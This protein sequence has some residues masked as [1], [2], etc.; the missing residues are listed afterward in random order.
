M[1]SQFYTV[2][3]NM[4]SWSSV[5]VSQSPLLLIV[6]LT[7]PSTRL[8]AAGWSRHEDIEQYPTW[9]YT[10]SHALPNGK[11]SLLIV[12]HGCDQAHA[13]IKE[14]G[15]LVNAAEANGIGVA[16]LFVG[17]EYFNALQQKCWDYA[18]ACN[19]ARL[20]LLAVHNNRRRARLADCA[21][22]MSFPLTHFLGR[23]NL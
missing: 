11:H 5:L 10:P 2:L 4:T 20:S 18:G 6:V 8:A 17:H 22:R 21:A 12:L 3:S 9:I 15:N 19:E 23:C 14:F 13:E 1:I 7:V 16:V